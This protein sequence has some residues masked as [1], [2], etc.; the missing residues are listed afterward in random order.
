MSKFE[1]HVE[2]IGKLRSLE[3][4]LEHVEMLLDDISMALEAETHDTVWMKIK[5]FIQ[6]EIK[7]D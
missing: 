1:E 4:R 5:R 7:K 3:S 2:I 6:R